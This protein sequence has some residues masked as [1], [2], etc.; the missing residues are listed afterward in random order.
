MKTA[1]FMALCMLFQALSL[2]AQSDHAPLECTGKIPKEFLSSSKSKYHQAIKSTARSGQ[3]RQET[4]ARNQFAL[5]S[6]FNIDNILRSGRVLFNDEVSSYLTDV[7][8]VLLQAKPLSGKQSIRLYALR[9]S[10]VNAF[11]TERGEVFVTLGLIAQLENEAQLAYVIAHELAHV[12]KKHGLN[13]HLAAKKL[14]RSK[15][16]SVLGRAATDEKILSISA[17]SKE[18][19]QEADRLGIERMLASSYRTTTLPVVFDVLKYSYLPFDDLPFERALLQSEHYRL[20]DGFWLNTVKPI[21]GEAGDEDD[22]RSSHPS[23]QSRRQAMLNTLANHADAPNK[24]DY[25]ISAGRFER[26]RSLA[27][28]ELPLLYLHTDQHAAAIYTAG[29]LLRERPDDLGLKK[30]IAKALYLHAKLK[31]SNNY[32]YEGDYNAIEGQSQ[33][34]HHLLEKLPAK[35]A[36]VLAWHFVWNLHRAHPADAELQSLTKDLFFEFAREH[37]EFAVLSNEPPVAISPSAA[38]AVSDQSTAESRSKYDRIREQQAEG[39]SDYWRHAFAGQLNDEAF[40]QYQKSAEQ[41]RDEWKKGQQYANSTKG[42][43]EF[44]RSRKEGLSLGIPKVVIVN[45]FYLKLD[46]RKEEPVQY[47]ETEEGQERFRALIKEAGAVSDLKTTLLDVRSLKEDQTEQ[48]N[49]IRYLNEWFAE[50]ARH[51][52]L[53]LTPGSRQARI[54]SIAHKYGTDYFLWTGVISLREKHTTADMAY[55][56]LSLFIFPPLTPLAVHN[57]V[58]PKHEMLHFSILYD[59]RTGRRQVLKFDTFNQ[60]DSDTIVKAHLYDAFVQIRSKG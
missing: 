10:A 35:E 15:G 43:K 58:K 44:K 49:D 22:H 53:T 55:V 33:Q 23:L 14:D 52:D 2:H 56:P 51:F 48:F 60:R 42:Q 8:D 16:S 50:Q 28:N 12:E 57:L 13:F 26:V 17:Y 7:T 6:N 30:C 40:A 27:R 37:D 5:E 47:I 20:P 46:E 3:K 24:S 31:N 59:V 45:P 36:T 29:L 19:E 18:N 34:M 9:S 54:D 38:E 21:E 25:L 41:R 4:K 11:A 39:R 1:F 32:E